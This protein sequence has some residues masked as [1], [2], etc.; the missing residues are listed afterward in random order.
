MADLMSVHCSRS[1][2]SSS[3]INRSWSFWC[4]PLFRYSLGMFLN[5]DFNRAGQLYIQLFGSVG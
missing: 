2:L 4:R 5:K 1:D 3:S